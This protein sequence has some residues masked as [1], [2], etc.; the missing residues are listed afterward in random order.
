MKETP[1]IFA[2]HKVHAALSGGGVQLRRVVAHRF[3]QLWE[4]PYYPTGKVINN[5]T[6]KLGSWI[7]YRH[8]NQ[9]DPDYPGVDASCLAP[10]PYGTI[11]DRLWVR[12]S[13]FAVRNT[14]DAV[15]LA[16]YSADGSY[17]LCDYG[18]ENR[19]VCAHWWYSKSRCPANHM[20]RWASRFLF[21]ITDIRLERVQDIS[22][23][24]AIAEGCDFSKS[25]AAIEAGWCEK[26]RRAF[27]RIWDLEQK[28]HNWDSNPWVWVFTLKPVSAMTEVN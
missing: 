28:T 10:C 6:G 25:K 27:R 21:E 16:K 17:V 13:A 3:P 19:N 14:S 24:D 9:G 22:E 15:E 18:E 8:R 1:I 20:P 5:P 26:P 11:G 23:E 12:E 4:E 7:E 2:E